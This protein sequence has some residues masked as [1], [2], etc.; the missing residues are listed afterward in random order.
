MYAALLTARLTGLHITVD[1]DQHRLAL[2][3]QCLGLPECWGD[4]PRSGDGDAY[5]A[6]T[7]SELGVV[8]GHLGHVK[9]FAGILILAGIGGHV[10]VVQDNG[11]DRRTGAHG[12]FDIQ[13]GHTKGAIAHEVE[14]EFVRFGQLCA[15]HQWNTVAEVGRLAPADVAVRDRRGVERHNGVAG[16]PSIVRDNAVLFIEDTLQLTNDPVGVNWYVIGT[17]YVRPFR[18]PL[19]LDVGDFGSHSGL[20][21]AA[22]WAEL[23]FDFLDEH[24]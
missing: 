13:T 8:A 11:R 12:R 4:V 22:I 1:V 21:L 19:L 7:L 20:T 15:N 24:L 14:T 10:P 3:V 2:G 16:R 6:H 23:G 18:H 9:Q 17:E 5:R